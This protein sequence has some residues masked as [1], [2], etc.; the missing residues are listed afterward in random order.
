MKLNMI[1]AK[2]FLAAAAVAG[3]CLPAI[4]AVTVKKGN[5]VNMVME[6]DAL[7][8]NIAVEAGGRISQLINKKTGHDLVALW[9]GNN[10]IGGALDDRN[11][12]TSFAYRAAVTRKGGDVGQI[13]LTAHYPG[14]MSME[15]TITLED[16]RPLIQITET[17]SN[18]GQKSNRFMIRNVLRPGGPQTNGI[19]HILS[20]KGKPLQIIPGAHGYYGDLSAPWTGVWDKQSGEGLLVAAPGVDKFYFY[21]NKTTPT[22][23][24]VYADVPPG[25]SLTVQFAIDVI[26]DKS[27]DWKTLSAATL[28][29]LHPMRSADLPDWQNEAQRFKVTEAE[30]REGF[31]LSTGD[32]TGKRRLPESPRID[33]PLK[34]SRSVYIGINALTEMKDAKLSVQLKD[35]PQGLVQTG[36]E[37]SGKGFI[38]VAPFDGS[39]TINVGN[40]SEGRLWLTLQGGDQPADA[41]GTVAITLNGKTMNVPLEAKVWGVNVPAVRPFAMRGYGG[42]PTLAGGYKITPATR[43]Q[44]DTLLGYFQAVGGNVLDL[45][46]SWSNMDRQLKLAGSDQTVFD[47]LRANR[48]AY[49][50][51]PAADW[52]KID[53]SYYDPWFKSAQAHGLTQVNA[54]LP[55]SGGRKSSD[56]VEQEWRLVQLKAYLK[57]KG[58]GP[59]FC[60]I[61]DEISPDEVPGYIESAKVAQRA[62]WRPLTTITGL[63][64]RTASEVNRMNPY[65]DKWVVNMMLTQF[66]DKTIHEAYDLK[67]MNLTMPAKWGKY[68]NGGA[69][70]TVAQKLFGTLIPGSPSDVERIEVFQDGKALRNGGGSPWGNK[71]PGVFFTNGMSLYISPLEGTDANKSTITVKYQKRVANS[72]GQPLA[73]IDP[74]D[75]VWFYGGASNSYQASYEAAAGYPLKALAGGYQGYSWYAFYRWNADKVIWYDNATGKASIGPAYL[76]LKDGWDDAR[77]LAWLVKEKKAP[78]DQFISQKADAPLRMGEVGREV[79][80]WQ[81]VVNLGDPFVL[82]AA[83]RGML[84]AAK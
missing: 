43:K 79:Y 73:K 60:K 14:G 3:F 53:F 52:P 5:G 16:D 29:G 78:L 6:N 26:N 84:E 49:D 15:K 54:Y 11:V 75:E 38:K 42:F 72:V 30:K 59:F 62:G 51:K 22:I 34:Q 83:R 77:L 12:F 28:K 58:F 67:E 63:I 65:C 24:W 64:A 35:I 45:T 17:F 13:R 9:K 69:R 39:T 70:D 46:V 4:G 80:K 50:G 56:P 37:E 18:G 44:T 71:K 32:D 25:K 66:F 21:P 55:L 74:T 10:Q 20:L 82:N 31:W 76:G 19:V 68:G 40:G 41:K 33:A 23:E 1:K 36:W 61:S 8:L 2:I 47:W 81:G 27:P 48:K 7:K 57:A